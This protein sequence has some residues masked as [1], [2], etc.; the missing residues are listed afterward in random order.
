[1]SPTTAHLTALGGTAQ[2]SA[3][4]LDQNG[5]AMAGATVTWASN[6][7]AVATVDPT[8][9]V[10]AGANGTATITATAGVASYSAFSVPLAPAPNR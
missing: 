7:A 5:Q 10:T 3:R 6:T 4:V 1:M 9:L 8:G 2:L